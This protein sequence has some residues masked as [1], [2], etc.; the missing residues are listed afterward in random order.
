VNLYIPSTVHWAEKGLQL[1]QK[2]NFPED[3]I[4]EFT[5]TASGIQPLSLNFFIPSWAA[6]VD[7]YVN[8]AKEKGQT[9]PASYF[10][11]RRTWKNN[12]V[13]KLV[14]HYN[15]RIETMPDDKKTI[16]LFY[17]PV[18][19]A[20][21]TQNE[22]ALK[23]TEDLDSTLKLILAG[24]HRSG[25]HKFQFAYNG[26]NYVLQPLYMIKQESYGVYASI[27]SY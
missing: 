1:Q 17:G 15:F 26:F 4:A 16:A 18:L 9:L 25:Q 13:V 7:V 24:I 5:V 27:R 11:L 6:K 3:S 14:F 10:S 8:G 2:G 23:K 22:I 12:D 19:L 20:F 21:E